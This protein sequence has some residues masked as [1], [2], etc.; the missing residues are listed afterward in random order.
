MT[1]QALLTA[2][3]TG[4]RLDDRYTPDFTCW[5]TPHLRRE[6][7]RLALPGATY[8][9]RHELITWLSEAWAS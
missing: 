6:A 4:A 7:D 2:L 1:K 8:M 5:S 9:S 3:Q